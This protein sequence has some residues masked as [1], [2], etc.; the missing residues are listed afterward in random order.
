MATML[1]ELSDFDGQAPLSES[2]RKDAMGHRRLET[3]QRYTHIRP[4]VERRAL[5]LI[6]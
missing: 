3:T 2:Q 6:Q 5:E 1:A 4:A